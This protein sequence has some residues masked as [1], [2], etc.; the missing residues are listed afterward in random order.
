MEFWA[1]VL[2]LWLAKFIYLGFFSG[3]NATITIYSGQT[4]IAHFYVKIIH[5][6]HVP[7]GH[8]VYETME[9]IHVP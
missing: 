6:A 4:S 5:K 8:N 1:I 7:R 2:Q 3:R 9:E